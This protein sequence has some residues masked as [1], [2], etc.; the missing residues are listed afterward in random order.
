[1]PIRCAVAGLNRGARFV[2]LL[3]ENPHCEVVAVCDDRPQKL[4]EFS[5]VPGYV[6]F[7]EMLER[8]RPDVAAIITPGPTHGP[9]SIAALQAGVHV[10]VETPNVYSV[11]EA[12]TVVGLTRAKGLKYMLA[13]DYIY[14]GW[15]RRLAEVV[16]EGK[17]GELLGGTAEYTHDCRGAAFV[18]EA[19][20][21]RPLS[22]EGESGLTPLW[23]LSGLPPLTYSSH[24]LGPLLELMDDR[25]V[26]VTG[27]GAGRREI[28]GLDVFPLQTA[29]L[30]TEQGRTVNLTNGFM[31]SHP[32]V[33]FAGL[34]GT[35]GSIR[36]ICTDYRGPEGLRVLIATD[37]KGS[38]W[39]DWPMAW[40]ERDDGRDHLEVM[41]DD[42]I[43]AIRTDSAPPFDEARSMDFC[44]PGVLAHESAKQGGETLQVPL[45]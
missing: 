40:Q 6:D 34:Y 16:N 24:T 27:L 13:E 9:L 20:Q 28:A 25:C 12:E 37:E 14:M 43:E 35:E 39:R 17:L 38:E 32:F 18:N 36:V 41:V 4:E 29:V 44:L 33:W 31:L 30:Q 23:R 7:G 2:A 8:A 15:C 26:N 5:G 45:Y 19:G 22:A 42:F 11:T 1:M 10:L 3:Q 21:V